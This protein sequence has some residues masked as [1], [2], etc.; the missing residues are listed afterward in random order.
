MDRHR[1]I[2]LD[3]PVVAF[4]EF[5]VSWFQLHIYILFRKVLIASR[6][7]YCELG[8][9]ER[10]LFRQP[11]LIWHWI[12]YLGG[13]YK[14]LPLF[15]DVEVVCS[16]CWCFVSTKTDVG[17]LLTSTVVDNKIAKITSISHFMNL[18]ILLSFFN[19]KGKKILV[20]FLLLINRWIFLS[21]QFIF[22]INE[23]YSKRKS[24]SRNLLI[25]YLYCPNKV[26]N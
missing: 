15:S 23:Q 22:H 3:W 26:F 8:Y 13:N 18:A 16:F 25:V 2:Q 4:S 10:T 12:I 7:T 1:Y 6:K 19:K 5:H 11:N 9:A 21:L 14:S 17:K 20:F 24:F